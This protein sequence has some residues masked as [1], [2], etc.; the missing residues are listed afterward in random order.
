MANKPIQDKETEVRELLAAGAVARRNKARQYVRP[1]MREPV[2]LGYVHMRV[3]VD[4]MPKMVNMWHRV[5]VALFRAKKRLS[6]S[7][8]VGFQSK[9]SGIKAV[10]LPDQFLSSALTGHT[11]VTWAY[12]AQGSKGYDMDVIVPEEYK[13]RLKELGFMVL[14]KGKTMY[15]ATEVRMLWKVEEGKRGKP[16]VEDESNPTTA[17]DKEKPDPLNGFQIK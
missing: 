6:L 16:E 4:S 1:I 8:L 17:A 15:S 11:N 12:S 13:D 14:R 7:A 2:D 3:S 9:L 10:E 5:R